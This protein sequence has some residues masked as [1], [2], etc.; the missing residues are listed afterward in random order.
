MQAAG[1]IHQVLPQVHADSVVEVVVSEAQVEGLGLRGATGALV[2]AMNGR[3]TVRSVAAVTQV[4]LPTALLRTAFLVERG[5][6]RV[7]R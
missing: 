1:A 2:A 6:V 5:I 4:D 3:R 7:V